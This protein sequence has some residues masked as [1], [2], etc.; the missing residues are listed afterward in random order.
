M[1]R[2]LEPSEIDTLKNDIREI[3]K[4]G[5]LPVGMIE[6][7][8]ILFDSHYA[9]EEILLSSLIKYLFKT[10]HGGR[11]IKGFNP[12]FAKFR[13]VA[14][15]LFDEYNLA[16]LTAI[17]FDTGLID[18]DLRR[19]LKSINRARVLF[20]HPRSEGYKVFEDEE[21]LKWLFVTVQEVLQKLALLDMGFEISEFDQN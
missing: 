7:R 9:L 2:I 16:R 14:L 12:A 19:K 8:E 10:S 21:M 13:N 15:K 3:V 6:A 4:V 17:A 20:A 18:D 1:L 11:T 5:G